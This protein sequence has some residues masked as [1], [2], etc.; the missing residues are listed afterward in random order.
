MREYK[1]YELSKELLKKREEDSAY[2]ET[3]DA[4]ITDMLKKQL[5]TIKKLLDIYDNE[6]NEIPI[7]DRSNCAIIMIGDKSKSGETPEMPETPMTGDMPETPMTGDMPE[8]P[9]TGDMPETPMTGDMPET[10]MTGDMPET[11]MTGDMPETPMTGEIPETP[12]T[13][14]MPETPMTGEMPE[15]PMTGET[16]ETPLVPVPIETTTTLLASANNGENFSA[17]MAQINKKNIK[18]T[19]S[20]ELMKNS[21]SESQSES[22]SGSNKSIEGFSDSFLESS[23]LTWVLVI[24]L[25]LLI[26]FILNRHFHIINF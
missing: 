2:N 22:G 13:G 18:L 17:P 23:T 6:E 10:T 14:E 1:M 26:L 16:P 19:P 21:N 3:V 20:A 9:M 7:F 5:Y 24:I 11:P 4:E 12:M 8:T 25:I 15:T